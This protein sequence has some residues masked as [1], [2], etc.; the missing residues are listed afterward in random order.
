MRKFLVDNLNPKTLFSWPV[1]IITL[2]WGISTNLLDRVFNPDGL[3]FERILVVIAGHLVMFTGIFIGVRVLGFFSSA[4]QAL[5]MIPL[6]LSVSVLRGFTVWN[7]FFGLGID[8]VET[9][10]YRVFG[11]ITN[12]GLPLTLTAMAL[13]RL[14]F[15]SNVRRKLLAESTRL[16]TF[17]EIAKENIR[18]SAESRLDEIRMTVAFSLGVGRDSTPNSTMAAIS[19]TIDDV[20]RPLS[21]QIENE[22]AAVSEVKELPKIRL[23]WPQA[24]LGA[25]SHKNLNPV[26][27]AS[28]LTAA[29]IIFVTSS[30]T[31]EES[32]YLLTITGFG[33]WSLLAALK[34]SSRWISSSVS[35]WVSRTLFVVGLGTSGFLLGAATLVVTAHTEDPYSVFFLAPYFLTGVS[36][37]FALASSTQSQAK[38][39]NERLQETTA[40][41]AW[42]VTRISDEQRQLRRVITG[43]LHGRLQSGLT[44]SLMRLK[45]TAETNPDRFSEVEAQVRQDL[46]A[47][48]DSVKLGD[49]TEQKSFEEVLDYLRQTWEG[50]ASVSLAVSPEQ[51]KEFSRDQVLMNTLSEL[52]SE[53]AFNAIK[54]GKATKIEFSV[55]KSTDNTVV[56]ACYDNG[57]QPEESGRI[58]LGTKLLGE[59]ALQWKRG[60]LEGPKGTLTEVMLPFSPV[61]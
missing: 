21:H 49:F 25:L 36:I 18:Q 59:C 51:S 2:S 6:V 55:S 1:F 39:A 12:M 8:S 50:I 5:L 43:L 30:R 40:D 7:L 4:Y 42:E 10:N 22:V 3:Y 26:V 32:A 56:L 27:V 14:R 20:V 19:A 60:P 46:I 57:S 48:V 37:L 47:L 33:S 11:P 23:N 15:F 44:S 53:L 45:M 52:L 31:P 9:F 38:A 41:L 35:P 13:Q 61:E 17:K 16:I 28:T 58:G 54:H 29:A 34:S 24:L